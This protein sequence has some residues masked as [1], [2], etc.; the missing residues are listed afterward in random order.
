MR[1]RTILIRVPFLVALVWLACVLAGCGSREKPTGEVY[2]KVSVGGKPVTAGM[3]KFVSEAA[4]ETPVSTGL[5]PDGSYRATG[6]PIGRSKV[7]IETLMFKNLTP[8]PPGIA[9]QLGGP[10]TKYVPIPD[11]YE[12]PESSGLTVEVERGKKQFDI[13]IP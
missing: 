3:V 2:G 13:E 12:R 4:D 11:K 10:R 1:A 8:P 5:G 9:K 7:A 6:V